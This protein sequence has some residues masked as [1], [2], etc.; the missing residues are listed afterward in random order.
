MSVNPL[1]VL[2]E[3]QAKKGAIISGSAGEGLVVQNTLAVGGASTFSGTAE[4]SGAATLSSSLTV[5]GASTLES[6]VSAQNGITVTGAS[7]DASAVS[8]SVAELTVVSGA[9]VGGK[10]TVQG[11][12]EVLGNINAIDRTTLTVTD[13]LIT[14]AS[15][16][17]TPAAAEGGGLKIAGAE[18]ELVYA[19]IGDKWTMNKRLD[20]ASDLNVAH[21]ASISGELSVGAAASFDA[22]LSVSGNL[23]TEANLEVDGTANID[24]AV[25]MHDGLTIDGDVLDAQNGATI[26]GGLTL[27]DTGLVIQ[28]GG[29]SVTG[30][31]AVDADISAA[32]NLS[33]GGTAEVEGNV[34]LGGTLDV[35]G[36]A[37]LSGTLAVVGAADLD[38]TLNVDGNAT[39]GGTLGVAGAADFDSTVNVDSNL[40]VL[41]S[42]SLTV[43]SGAESGGYYDVAKAIKLLDTN[44]GDNKDATIA[45]Y[46]AMR[47][48]V[49]GGFSSGQ[50]T[51]NLTASGSAGMFDTGSLDYIALDV[52]VKGAEGEWTNDLVAVHMFSS[53]SAVYVQID[54][55]TEATHYRVLA[56]NEKAGKFN[57]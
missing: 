21:S 19:S 45:G 22:A 29:A 39:L 34:I 47:L 10:L 14:A 30:S 56:V 17:S 23:S 15:G 36:N 1:K 53:S 6:A 12:L 48:Q 28:G 4:I 50:A 43:I 40:T 25:T 49:A 7:L 2:V 16:A 18:A 51:V 35:V 5:K 24:G 32:A 9:Y 3:L 44:V 26:T 38:S 57:W 33:I 20:L 54:A 55:L 41:A 31:I 27:V 8:A 46:E 52:M 13:L 37:A 11:D 42:G